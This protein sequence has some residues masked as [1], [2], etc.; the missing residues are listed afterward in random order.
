MQFASGLVVVELQVPPAASRTGAAR[1]VSLPRA[2]RG[3][4]ASG[5]RLCESD[6]PDQAPAP[7]EQKGQPEVA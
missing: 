2:G 4:R 1:A 6:G 5:W 7:D 3:A